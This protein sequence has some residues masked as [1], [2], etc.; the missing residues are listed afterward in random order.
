MP[1]PLHHWQMDRHRIAGM[2]AASCVRD[3]SAG[4]SP[5]PPTAPLFPYTSIKR[6][7]NSFVMY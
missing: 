7:E 1:R 3:V 2:Q 5:L 6:D 4:I